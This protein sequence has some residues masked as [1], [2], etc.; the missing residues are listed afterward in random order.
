MR[1]LLD[2]HSLLWALGDPGALSRPARDVLASP[3]TIIFVSSASLWECAIKASIGKLDLPDDFFDAIPETGY[4][5]LP[6]RLSH[7]NEYRAL[8]LHHRDPFD[9]MFVAQARAEA[10]TLIT[11]DPEIAKYDV[12][13]LKC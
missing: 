4:E 8:P 3:A 6:I 10:L 12:A 2:T 5:V 7:L 9:R 11:R 1:Y 13:L